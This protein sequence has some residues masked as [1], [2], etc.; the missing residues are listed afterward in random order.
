MAKTT[1]T[2]TEPRSYFARRL[3]TDPEL[4]ARCEAIKQELRAAAAADIE[5]GRRS[6]QLTGDALK[7]IINARAY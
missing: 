6:E 2:A 4:A 7:I 1:P 5:A 3:A